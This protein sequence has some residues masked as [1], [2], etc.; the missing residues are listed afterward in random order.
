MHDTTRRERMKGFPELLAHLSAQLDAEATTLQAASMSLAEYVQGQLACSRVTAWVLEGDVGHR[1]MRR[2]AGFD[3]V[4]RTPITEPA[5]LHEEEFA[6]YFEA[7]ASKGVYVCPD[8][9]AA[10]NLAAMRDSYLIPNRI[11]ASLDVTIGVNASTWGVCCCSQQGA[12]RQWTPQEVRM[13]RRFAHAISVRRAR[14]RRREAEAA[15]LVQRLLLSA[16]GLLTDT[17]TS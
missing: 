5:Q 4:S 14:R 2:I 1:V 6:A 15:T 7:L 11:G 8:T 9:Q 16:V 13:V 10:P 17:P 12:T 3:G